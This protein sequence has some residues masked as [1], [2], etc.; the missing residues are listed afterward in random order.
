MLEEGG[1]VGGE[2]R[3]ASGQRERWWRSSGDGKGVGV[4]ERGW[5]GE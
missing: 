5:F 4:G 1:E 2:G 3:K